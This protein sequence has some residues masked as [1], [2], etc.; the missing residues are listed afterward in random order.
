MENQA[1]EGA[2]VY[3]NDA[4]AYE[5]LK[6]DHDSV[7][8][9]L[10]EYV[11]GGVQTNGIES[12]WSMLKRAHKGTFQELSPKHLD[13]FVQEFAGRH[14]VREVDTIEQMKPLRDGMEGR[15]PTS[16]ALIQDNGL[17]SGARAA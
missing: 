6:F 12:L 2:T 13:R 10:E 17:S 9:S 16:K 5:T 3:T 7:R 1:G 15:R 14:N 8:H 4:S 11:M